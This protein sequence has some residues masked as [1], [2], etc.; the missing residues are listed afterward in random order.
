MKG[1]PVPSLAWEDH[2]C[3]GATKP[4]R[5]KYWAHALQLLKPGALEPVL[6]NVKPLQGEART[7]QLYSTLCSPKLE[8]WRHSIVKKK[9]PNFE[10]KHTKNPG[11]LEIYLHWITSRKGTNK[12]GIL[13]VVNNL[14]IYCSYFLTVDPRDH[15]DSLL[16]PRVWREVWVPGWPRC[17]ISG[18]RSQARDSLLSLHCLRIKGSFPASLPLGHSL[19]S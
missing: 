14:I 5:H 13:N 9:R 12:P 15:Q 19:P 7:P 1:T 10:N 4:W 6:H 11:P 2:T 17:F 18:P 3:C 8:K 16:L